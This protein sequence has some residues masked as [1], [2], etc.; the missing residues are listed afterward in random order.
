MHSEAVTI[1]SNE[2]DY[3]FCNALL[4]GGGGAAEGNT[5]P[6]IMFLIILDANL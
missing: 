1:L 3:A 6:R 2:G 5:I 4:G